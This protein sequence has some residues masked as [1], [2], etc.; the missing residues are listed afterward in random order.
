MSSFHIL[1]VEDEAIISVV[2]QD[3]LSAEG[4]RVTACANANEAWNA[5]QAAAADFDLVLLDRGLPDLDGMALLHRIKREPGFAHIPVIFE[6]AQSDQASIREGLANGAYYYMTKPFQ[7]DVLLAVVRAALQ[8]AGEYRALVESVKRA[9]SLPSLMYQGC[10][11]FRDLE[12]ARLLANNLARACPQPERAVQGLQELLV[13]AVEHGNLGISYADKS[14]LM[15]EGTWYQEVQRRLQWPEYRQ[16]FVEV[17]FE[18]LADRLCF[19]IQDQGAGFDWRQY[20]D[21][22]PERA[23]DLNGRGI[24]MA[25]KLSVDKLD[26]QGN[27]NS[28]R[29]TF[30]IN[31]AP[32]DT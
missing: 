29:L 1:L 30:V 3:L 25:G 20:L 28:V 9:E 26:Y 14:R 4:Y 15:M 18:R 5:L 6:T 19:T 7:A 16:R 11:R 23:F 21:F 27:G 31:S 10:F 12:Q 2:I 8:Q 22:S 32:R 24:A 17:V 13:N